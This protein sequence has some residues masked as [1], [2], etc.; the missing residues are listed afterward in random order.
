MR[1]HHHTCR[2][3]RAGDTARHASAGQE[4]GCTRMEPA[5]STMPLHLPAPT[6][7]TAHLPC[8]RA[9]LHLLRAAH[10]AHGLPHCCCLRAA[11]TRLPHTRTFAG[12]LLYI[13]FARPLLRR[14]LPAAHTFGISG[15]RLT[16]HHRTTLPPT[17]TAYQHRLYQST[18]CRYLAIL[19]RIRPL[20]CA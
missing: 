19:L 16:F 1:H 20:R 11:T 15:R 18:F 7:R 5:T 14:A 8:L 17:A 13:L 10:R 9:H 4:G 2:T 3:P 12:R 6:A